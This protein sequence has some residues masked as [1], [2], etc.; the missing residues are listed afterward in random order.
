MLFREILGKLKKRRCSSRKMDRRVVGHILKL[1]NSN[2]YKEN[3]ATHVCVYVYA[4]VYVSF[5][6][7]VYAYA[8]VRVDVYVYVYVNFYV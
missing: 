6:V 2:N 1:T 8:Y 5:Y 4:Y 3:H 7:F